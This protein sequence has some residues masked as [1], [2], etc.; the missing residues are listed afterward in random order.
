[1][2]KKKLS[3]R[4]KNV[5]AVAGCQLLNSDQSKQESV[6]EFPNLWN[7]FCENFFLYKLFPN[8][9]IFNKYY[10]TNIDINEPIE[11]DVV[12]GA[13]LIAPTELLLRCNGFDE[14]FFFYSEET[15]LCYRLKNKLGAKIY[16]FPELKVIHHGG[17]EDELRSWFHYKNV[18]IGK[19]KYSQ[20][21]LKGISFF[22]FLILHFIGISIRVFL[23]MF[24]SLVKREKAYLI[25][26]KYFGKLLCVY[27]KNEF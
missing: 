23:Y 2:N 9:K 27:P 8:S 6:V 3:F 5:D 11:V 13:F 17:T 19:I 21:H 4:N 12:K 18:S 16:L 20:K 25:K 15:D 10:L 7:T 26:A 14:R 24:L 22:L 1:M